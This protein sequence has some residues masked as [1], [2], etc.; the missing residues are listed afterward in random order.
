MTTLLVV[1]AGESGPGSRETLEALGAARRVA[2]E[3]G[4]RVVGAALGPPRGDVA[5]DLARHGAD[6]VW[7]VEDARVAQVDAGT[8]LAT[9]LAVCTEVRP[10]AILLPAGPVG[11]DLAGRL[12]ARLSAAAA[13]GCVGLAWRDGA[14]V[15]HRPVYGGRAVARLVPR[16]TPVV[17]TLKPRAFDPAPAV[18][19]RRPTVRR[20]VPD[21]AG[22]RAETRPLER[23]AEAALGAALETARVVVS[24][25]RGLGGP[26]PFALLEELAALLGGAVGASRVATDAGWAAPS[27]QVGQTGRT[28]SPDLYIAVG[29]SGATQHLAGMSR[30]KVV[31]AV[32]TDPEAPIFSVAH[33]GVVGDYAA[34]LPA[35]LDR[36]REL[37]AGPR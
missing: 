12:A 26:A 1:A 9:L 8:L 27:R 13:T 36:L 11:R 19:G 21:L 16:A 35:L 18:A 24:G 3:A 15:L 14:L 20:L 2:D 23:R 17:V 33:L 28:V 10:D 5:D 22:A 29:I 30:S 4:G 34:V 6:E 7:L 25:G 31:V 37:G 32:N